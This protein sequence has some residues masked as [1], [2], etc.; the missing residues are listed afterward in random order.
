MELAALVVGALT[1]Q[2][3]KK[4]ISVRQVKPRVI[5][6]RKNIGGQAGNGKKLPVS[7]NLFPWSLG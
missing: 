5:Q 4:N 1:H 2:E 6:R 7:G 3:Q